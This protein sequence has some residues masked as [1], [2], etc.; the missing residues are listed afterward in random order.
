MFIAV[1]NENF[2]VAEGQKRQQQ[3]EMYLKKAEGKDQSATAG[4]LNK[5]SPYRYLRDRNAAILVELLLPL[6]KIKRKWTKR[7]EEG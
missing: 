4:L 6:L 7:E 1:I 2:N 3:I 5:L